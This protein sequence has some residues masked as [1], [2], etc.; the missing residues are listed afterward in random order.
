ME[1]LST[2]ALTR[3]Y[4]H[5]RTGKRKQDISLCL[6]EY[7]HT[8]KHTCTLKYVYVHVS[9][10]TTQVCTYVAPHVLTL[11]GAVSN[12]IALAHT[13]WCSVNNVSQSKAPHSPHS[14][15]TECAFKC[16]MS[17]NQLRVK[18]IIQGKH[19]QRQL[20]VYEKRMKCHTYNNTHA[21]THTHRVQTSHIITSAASHFA[22]APSCL[23][24]SSHCSLLVGSRQQCLC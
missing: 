12:C 16:K 3:T 11:K 1:E 23:Q 10:R 9:T 13:G 5:S 2:H 17:V 14:Y 19:R 18:E 20:T 7:V 8:V 22:V 24:S 15:K 21:H 4:T 6:T